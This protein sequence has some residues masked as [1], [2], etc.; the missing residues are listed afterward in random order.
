MRLALIEK[1]N[2]LVCSVYSLSRERQQT[3]TF[4]K[5]HKEKLN[6]C[7]SETRFLLTCSP[8]SG[9]FSLQSRGASTLDSEPHPMWSR[10]A[11]LHVFLEALETSRATGTNE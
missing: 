10:A 5:K 6:K 4:L 1:A 7:K 9:M 11:N 3:P 8:G 2:L